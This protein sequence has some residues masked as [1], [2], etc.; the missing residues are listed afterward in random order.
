[1]AT[2]QIVLESPPNAYKN[3]Q[4]KK[5]F[6]LVNDYTAPRKLFINSSDGQIIYRRK[7][8]IWTKRFKAY[9]KEVAPDQATIELYYESG[10]KFAEIEVQG[11]YVRL[12]PGEKTSFWG[13]WILKKEE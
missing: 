10:V 2:K 6:S 9:P 7:G 12:E 1:L 5:Q 3:I 4:V 11:P 8:L 13:E